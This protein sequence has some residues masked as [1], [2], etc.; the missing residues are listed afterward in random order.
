MFEFKIASKKFTIP[1]FAHELTLGQFVKLREKGLT[2]MEQLAIY[3]NVSADELTFNYSDKANAQLRDAF[4]MAALLNEDIKK[5]GSSA[6]KFI[7]P[8]EVVI[9]GKTIKIPQDLEKEPFW[10]SRKVKEILEEQ[11]KATGM[12]E[13]FDS[14]DKMADVL[15]HYLY[16]PFTGM[17]YNEYRAEEFKE[18]IYDLPLTV[19]VPLSNF[20]FLQWKRL[21]LTK[22]RLF[23][24]NFR[25]WRKKLA[26]KFSKTTGI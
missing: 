10:P 3:C 19:A 15:A 18:A 4:V 13:D 20:F 5:Y 21:Y 1:Q 16:V 25:L 12:N 2:V 26:W 24:V 11:I 6:E 8:K 17:K 9:L 14:T 23:L 22:P 7:T